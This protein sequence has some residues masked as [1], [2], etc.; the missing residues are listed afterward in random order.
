M[1]DAVILPDRHVPFSF[2]M[3]CSPEHPRLRD[4]DE[5][6]ACCGEDSSLDPDSRL[7]AFVAPLVTLR[8]KES[9]LVTEHSLGETETPVLGGLTEEVSAVIGRGSINRGS[10]FAMSKSREEAGVSVPCRVSD[11]VDA[12]LEKPSL[13]LN[14]VLREDDVV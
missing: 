3:G 6:T 10:I 8:V 2:C 12:S 13:W 9:V 14:L 5:G 4:K 11:S 7:A 1:V